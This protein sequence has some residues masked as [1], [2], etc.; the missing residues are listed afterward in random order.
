MDDG[1]QRGELGAQFGDGLAAVVFLAAVAVAVDGEQHDGL[2]LLEAVEDAAGAEVGGAGGPDPAD[3]GGGEERDDGLGDVGEVA[4][5]PVAGAYAEGA[6]FG[7]ER[8][9]LAAELR[10]GDGDRLVALVDAD[11]GR[12]PGAGRVLG[13]AQGVLGVVEGGAGEP[14]G[15]RHGAVGEDRLVGGGE[16]QVEPL[17]DGLPEGVEFV[18][19]PAVEGGVA[20]FGGGAVVLGG[21]SLECGDPGRRDPFGARGP[22]G[23]RLGG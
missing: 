7:G 9:D 8:P 3:G 6:Q 13:G 2:D 10:P 22:E 5:D 18:D 16:A 17:G 15:A 14:A 23:F 19:G 4:A 1:A 20:A 12:L 11:Q 21:P